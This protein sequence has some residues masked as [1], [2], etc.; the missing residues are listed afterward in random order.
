MTRTTGMHIIVTGNPIEG[1]RFYGP[2]K[3][4]DDAS[5]V[6]KDFCDGDWWLA[7]LRHEDDLK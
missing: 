4:I 1:L 6:A 3:T 7:P 5:D 2:F